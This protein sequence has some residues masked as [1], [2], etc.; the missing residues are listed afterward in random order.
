MTAKST[1]PRKKTTLKRWRAFLDVAT[2]EVTFLNHYAD[3][4][5]QFNLIAAQSPVAE[6]ESEFWVFSHRAFAH[7]MIFRICRL[8]EAQARNKGKVVRHR[9]VHS[10]RGVLEEFLEH[11]EF[12][13]REHYIG[14]SPVTL[15]EYTKKHPNRF[16]PPDAFMFKKLNRE[17]DEIVGVGQTHVS[18]A[19][20][21]SDIVA[22]IAATKSMKV[23]RDKHLAHIAVKK[24]RFKNPKFGEI[25]K[26]IRVI[27]RVMRK[28]FLI[29]N[30][31]YHPLNFGDPDITAIFMKSWI[32]D[33][34]AKQAILSSFANEKRQK[35]EEQ[36]SRKRK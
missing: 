30:C 6:T 10:L 19:T 13:S 34:E 27:D 8:C 12:L 26:A 16:N 7:E 36:N 31:S 17:F 33:T 20:V 32:A 14:V 29:F 35:S 3:I 5:H 15:E 18:K 1:N 23:Y 24:G 9:E 22:L 28:Y 2:K 25:P 11:P 21:A 4:R